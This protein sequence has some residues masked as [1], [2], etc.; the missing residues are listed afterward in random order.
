MERH[1]MNILVRSSECFRFIESE[2]MYHGITIN[3]EFENKNY[4]Y[5]LWV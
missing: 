4:I 3:R 1:L 5:A 2:D